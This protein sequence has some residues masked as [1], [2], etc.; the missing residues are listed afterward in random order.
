MAT[1]DM[2]TMRYINL[3]D[4]TS[5]VKTTKCFSYNNAIIFAVPR[6]MIA[7]ALGPGASNIRRIQD[8]IG[9]KIRIIEES[10]GVDDAKRFVESVV[11]P[12]NFRSLEVKEGIVVLT[13]GSQSKAALIGRNKRRYDELKK[14]IH[15]TYGLDL[16]IV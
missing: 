16:R 8:E 13:A 4:K 10:N 9:R 1:I 3:L 15:D 14:I 11:S 2:Q 12:I 5:R 6:F 7:K